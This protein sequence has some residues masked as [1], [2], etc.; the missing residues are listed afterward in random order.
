MSIRNECVLASVLLSLAIS[1]WVAAQ[2]ANPQKQDQ[3]Q[4]QIGYK[5]AAGADQKEDAPAQRLSARSHAAR[6]GT[7]R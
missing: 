4:E 3:S 2:N 6:A 1:A 7:Q 5:S